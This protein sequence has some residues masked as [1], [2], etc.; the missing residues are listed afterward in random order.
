MQAIEVQGRV[1]S[2]GSLQIN[3]PVPLKEGDVK[4]IIL[5]PEEKALPE[6]PLWW[7]AVSRNP[8]FSFLNDKEEEYLFSYRRKALAWLKTK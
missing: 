7:Q 6:E 5:Y 3:T 4:V 1:D 8:A 2:S